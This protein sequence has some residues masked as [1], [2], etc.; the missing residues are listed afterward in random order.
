MRGGLIGAIHLWRLIFLP[1]LLAAAAS[2][3]WAG[4]APPGSVPS[5]PDPAGAEA[6][7]T[8]RLCSPGGVSADQDGS[9]IEIG[10]RAPGGQI[11]ANVRALTVG[12]TGKRILV[13][14]E[15]DRRLWLKRASSAPLPTD[16]LVR[17]GGFT[18][19]LEIAAVEAA[20]WEPR[21]RL[22]RL[23][24]LLGVLVLGEA[25]WSSLLR[26]QVHKQTATIRRQK[27]IEA[28]RSRILEDINSA[29]PLGAIV[30]HITEMLALQ[31]NAIHCWCDVFE[32]L[33][34]GNAPEDEQL[35]RLHTISR[36]V[37]SRSGVRLGS[38]WVA[39]DRPWTESRFDEE[40]ALA[41]GVRLTALAIETRKLYA[42]L[43]RRSE[44]DTLTEIYNRFSLNR[45]VEELIAE[46]GGGDSMFGL[47]YVD[48]DDFKPI[49]DRYGHQVGDLVLQ[50]AVQRMKR[51]L[52]G[53]DAL[54]RLGGDEFAAV[55][56][57]TDGRP[58]VEEIAKRLEHC[59]DTPFSIEGHALQGGASVGISMYP[60]NGTTA[61]ELFKAADAAMYAK[62]GDRPSRSRTT[63]APS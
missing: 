40:R 55:I 58:E 42:D 10:W 5:L 56:S 48:L 36:E 41:T 25:V 51:Q 47:I 30:E 63:S 21:G 7:T 61:E 27:E 16:N 45:L 34:F 43:I 35:A 29:R 50:E 11:L 38:L 54:G 15:R 28:T 57:A 13:G 60:Q 18:D 46:A 22:M 33:R 8:N 32:R 24:A 1:G 31:L 4:A 9:A 20:P 44:Y 17:A 2:P 23:I 39:F 49:N 52:R 19:L 37:T 53:G 12:V 26:R 14:A 6:A 62:K 59:F 3:A